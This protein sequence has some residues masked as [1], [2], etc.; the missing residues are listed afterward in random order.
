MERFLN[1]VA[2]F[3]N[4]IAIVALLLMFLIITLDILSSKILNRPI[5][6]TVDIMSLLAAIVAAFS[7]SMTIIAG[8]HIEVEFIVA[9]MPADIR[10]IFNITSNLLAM[11]FFILIVWR[12]FVYARDLQVLGEATLTQHIPVAPFVYGIGIACIPGILIYAHRT[13]CY[14]KGVR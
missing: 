8:R 2:T 1:R 13:Y 11:S 4:W 9:K 10:K 6:A 7:L 5:T 12:S 3:F 14:V